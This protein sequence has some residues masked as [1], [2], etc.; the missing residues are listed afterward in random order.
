MVSY[1]FQ[2]KFVMETE[3]ELWFF[4]LKVSVFHYVV[5]LGTNAFSFPGSQ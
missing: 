2:H 3:S 4:E 5:A 1:L